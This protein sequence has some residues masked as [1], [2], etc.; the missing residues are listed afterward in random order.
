MFPR[1][2]ITPATIQTRVPTPNQASNRNAS[3]RDNSN[4]PIRPHGM[5]LYQRWPHCCSCCRVFRYIDFN[6]HYSYFFFY[7][8]SA[9]YLHIVSIASF[10]IPLFSFLIHF[11][12]SSSYPITLSFPHSSH[13]SFFLPFLFSLSPFF[14]PF[15]LAFFLSSFPPSYHPSFLPF[16]LSSFLPFF[17]PSFLPSYLPSIHLTGTP[18]V[19]ES[20]Q[21]SMCPKNSTTYGSLTLSPAR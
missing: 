7:S 20:M 9:P 6:Y 19:I 1:S 4:N 14:L 12:L 16:F 15:F 18:C 5:K 10:L 17:L 13:L 2:C 11:S 21:Q 8:S 3:E